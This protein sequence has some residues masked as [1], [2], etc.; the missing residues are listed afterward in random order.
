MKDQITYAELIKNTTSLGECRIWNGPTRK[1]VPAICIDDGTGARKRYPSVRTMIIAEL[2]RGRTQGKYVA[3]G[4]GNELC[5]NE[6]HFDY[7]KT[8]LAVSEEF[9]EETLFPV[10][11]PAS[12]VVAYAINRR[13]KLFTAWFASNSDARM[14]A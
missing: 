5:I 2:G 13:P 8:T 1:G 7:P 11:K 10:P 4:C 3:M 14:A 12:E 6:Y 9:D